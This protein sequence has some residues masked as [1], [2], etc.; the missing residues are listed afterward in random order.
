MIQLILA[1]ILVAIRGYRSFLRDARQVRDLMGRVEQE[2]RTRSSGTSVE[3][4][5]TGEY[6]LAKD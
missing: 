6:Q 2:A 3:N 4:P 1:A 5:A